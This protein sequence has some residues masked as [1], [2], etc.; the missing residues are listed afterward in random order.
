LALLVYVGI[1]N[2]NKTTGSYPW[3]VRPYLVTH[4]NDERKEIF[5]I[6]FCIEVSIP[7]D[8]PTAN[9]FRERMD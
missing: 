4:S 5:F 3:R 7:L 2:W 6:E 8:W 1:S 9:F